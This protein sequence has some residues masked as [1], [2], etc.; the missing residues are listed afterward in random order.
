MLWECRRMP[1]SSIWV[2]R[3]RTGVN[4]GAYFRDVRL[5]G[6]IRYHAG[7]KIFMSSCA[8]QCE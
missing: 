7:G 8:L 1:E 2:G 5:I 4:G 3:R 6:H